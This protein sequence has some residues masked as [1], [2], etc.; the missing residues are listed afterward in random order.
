ME[1]SG[2]R[3]CCALGGLFQ[4]I[5]TDMKSSY[6][7][8]EDFIAKAMKFHTQ[9]RTTMGIATMFLDAFQKIADLATN[10]R[11]ATRDIGSA[12][13]R[14]CLRH[15]TIE[16]KLRQLSG[17]LLDSLINPLQEHLEDWKRTSG[18]L[19]KEH[20][21]GRVEYKRARHEI[22]RRSLESHKLQKKVRKGKGEAQPQ[23]DSALAEVGELCAVLLD[24]EKQA[25]RR[26]LIEERGRF[27]SFVCMLQPVVKEEV[28]MLEEVTHLQI[29][30]EDLRKLTM[31][32]HCL[33]ASSEQV[34]ADM[35]G[36][37]FSWTYQTPP[38]SPS[39]N[40]SRKS[41]MCSSAS[42]QSS[43]SQ[44]SG[45]A[46]QGCHLRPR[47]FPCPPPPP[48]TR[49]SSVSSHDSGFLS[50]DVACSKPPSP[51]PCD[52]SIAPW[53]CCEGC[54][55]P[56]AH[57]PS[58]TS[59]L[60]LPR[61]LRS[62]C[63]SVVTGFL[64]SA[65]IPTWKDWS[66]PGP[67][68]QPMVNTLRRRETKALVGIDSGQNLSS[69]IDDVHT[70]D[71]TEDSRELMLAL[72]QDVD[73]NIGTSEHSTPGS[74]PVCTDDTVS[75][76]DS[77]CSSLSGDGEVPISIHGSWSCPPPPV[78]L[79]CPVRHSGASPP[80]VGQQRVAMA[81]CRPQNTSLRVATIRRHPSSKPS[82]LRRTASATVPIPICPP[83]VPP[84]RLPAV[85]VQATSASG[86]S[87]TA[88]H[89]P[90]AEIPESIV[91]PSAPTQS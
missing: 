65:S 50:Q 3:E 29:L 40:S 76:H 30:L 28:A 69:C 87:E 81:P 86:G 18:Q 13:T 59:S 34:L 54:I 89:L 83:V 22:K 78:E 68:D 80:D 53:V 91:T 66:R 31:D 60:S 35:K 62:F 21:K 25:A 17:A 88:R 56:K 24:T 10:S 11:G 82:L 72:T 16:G 51:L 9:L 58:R 57:F 7:V 26:A 1:M 27:C 75:T 47:G 90:P 15:K 12:L 55:P 4:A 64:P 6:P 63:P 52:S 45:S 33:P 8:W 44:S 39:S 19:D 32:P 23:L 85:D 2:D 14:M 67:Y 41:S 74:T 61:E 48:H 84:P 36:S 20:N 77:D 38:S 5:I 70:K 49:L 71:A 43:D 73:A 46:V 42:F 79:Y 37:D